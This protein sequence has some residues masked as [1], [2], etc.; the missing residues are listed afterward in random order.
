M[1]PR[2]NAKIDQP[3]MQKL[4]DHTSTS[5]MRNCRHRLY[6]LEI[7]V[8]K[9]KYTYKLTFLCS[10]HFNIRLAQRQVLFY[11][12]DQT[13]SKLYV[14]PL[15]GFLVLLVAVKMS[16]SKS[17]PVMILKLMFWRAVW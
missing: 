12:I 17:F 6:K 5:L 2:L 15:H 14:L 10:R 9:I 11:A 13:R 1:T 16:T 7:W 4:K 3:G 8:S